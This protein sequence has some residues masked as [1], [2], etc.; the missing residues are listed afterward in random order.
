MS[1]LISSATKTDRCLPPVQPKAIDKYFDEVFNTRNNESF[2]ELISERS[3]LNKR[4]KLIRKEYNKC[5][6]Q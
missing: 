2:K 4:R 6:N 1:L 3:L 5:I